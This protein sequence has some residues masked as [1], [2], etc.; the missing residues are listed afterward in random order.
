M[1]PKERR[2]QEKEVLKAKILDAA[3]E[4]FAT[5]GYEAVTMRKIAEK[6]GYTTTALYVHFQDKDA[7]LR[8]LCENDFRSLRAAFERIAKIHD[9]IERLYKLGLAYADFALDHANQ[10]RLMFMT[11]TPAQALTESVIEHGN[12]DV[13]AYAFLKATI[14]AGIA[15]G[16]YRPE[17]KD[18]DLIAQAV[19]GSVHGVVSLYLTKASDSWVT[20][21]PIRKTVQLV[22]DA[23]MR[24]LLRERK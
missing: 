1:T 13:E 19:W 22:I 2:Q 20:W 23:M 21:R 8:A 9:P 11:P 10:Y 18:P 24:G 14:A 4:L 7:L 12:P 6:I 16:C 17:H 15:A 3:R 5:E